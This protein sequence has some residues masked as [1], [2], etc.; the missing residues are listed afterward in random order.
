MAKFDYLYIFITTILIL[1][2]GIVNHEYAHYKIFENGCTN[3]SDITPFAECKSILE[4]SIGFRTNMKSCKSWVIEQQTQNEIIG[5]NVMP[6]LGLIA[7]LLNYIYLDVLY[8]RSNKE[9]KKKDG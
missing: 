8:L 1:G 3:M 5:Y 2:A 7:C 9:N 4:C 6:M